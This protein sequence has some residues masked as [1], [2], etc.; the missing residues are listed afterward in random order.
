M[1]VEPYSREKHGEV[2]SCRGG[3]GIPS[4]VVGMVKESGP[5]VLDEWTEAMRVS[6]GVAAR[7]KGFAVFTRRVSNGGLF[8]GLRG[9][10]ERIMLG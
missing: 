3:R 1:L 7:R 4:L 2:V 10:D 8:V 5:V 9:R 6:I